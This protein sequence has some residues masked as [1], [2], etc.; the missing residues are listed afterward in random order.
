MRCF[1]LSTLR[2][3]GMGKRL[4]EEKIFCEMCYLKEVF[5]QFKSSGDLT[6]YKKDR[7][8]LQRTIKLAKR[9]YR[10]RVESNHL[11]SDLRRMWS[12]PVL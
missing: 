2:D 12:G 5:K 7:Y 1:A 10:D 3:F 8:D 4:S 11:G 6:S 9:S